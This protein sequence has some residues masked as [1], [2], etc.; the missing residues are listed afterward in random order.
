M[1]KTS[2]IILNGT[3]DS[4]SPYFDSD[5]KENSQYFTIKYDVAVGFL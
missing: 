1:A 4:G 2:C 3:G 5:I